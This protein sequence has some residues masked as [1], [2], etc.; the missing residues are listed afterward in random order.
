MS[1]MAYWNGA[2]SDTSSNLTY[3]KQGTIIGS[4]NIG[5]QSV[6]FATSS[7]SCSGNAATATDANAVGG[8][9]ASDL[10]KFYLSPMASGA[11]ATSAKS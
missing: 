10:V 7:G 8:Y 9:A 1:F 2:Y 5:S 6:N 3:C 4:K 11:P